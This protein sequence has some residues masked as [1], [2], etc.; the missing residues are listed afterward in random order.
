[1]HTAIDAL[2]R[3]PSDSTGTYSPYVY[4]LAALAE[5]L[6]YTVVLHDS[7]L[8]AE[9]VAVG[10]VNFDA[11]T[12]RVAEPCAREAVM[13]LAHEL[14]HILTHVRY[15]TRY[16]SAVDLPF[17]MEQRAYLF[18]WVVLRRAGCAPGLISKDDW[19]GHHSHFV[20]GVVGSTACAHCGR[21]EA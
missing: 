4:R 9:G 15:S 20:A 2:L 5:R 21:Q 7:E 11:K 14:G 13:V 17:D 8:R 16:P 12:L 1:M 18:G 6:G 19:R 10:R 3:S